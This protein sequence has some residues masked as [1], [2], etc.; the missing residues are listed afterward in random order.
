MN[1]IDP[2]DDRSSHQ[3]ADIRD[4]S[5]R[6]VVLLVALAVIAVAGGFGARPAYRW[7]KV[8]RALS[9][10][11]Q[12][13]AAASANDWDQVGRVVQTT[14]RLAPDELRVLRL[15]ARYCTEKPTPPGSTTGRWCSPGPA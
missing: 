5:R 8:K 14:L 2:K 10:V 12:G 11:T 7:F 9:M 4:T 1:Y 15:A 3:Y 13:E 6:F